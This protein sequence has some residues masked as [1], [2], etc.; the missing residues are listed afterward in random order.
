MSTNLSSVG[1]SD[2]QRESNR[3]QTTVGE[4]NRMSPPNLVPSFVWMSLCAP[5]ACSHSQITVCE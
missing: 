3:M 4:S 5:L 1:I 2:A